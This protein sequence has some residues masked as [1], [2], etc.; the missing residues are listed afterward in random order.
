MLID[1][2]IGGLT[3]EQGKLPGRL[4][5]ILDLSDASEVPMDEAAAWG[6]AERFGGPSYLYLYMCIYIQMHVPIYL[7][8][9]LSSRYSG[10]VLIGHM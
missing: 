8:I 9:Y 4:R 1:W 7:S 10:T 5:K 2:L 3:G 6:H